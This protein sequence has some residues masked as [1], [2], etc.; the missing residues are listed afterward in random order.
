MALAP[1]GL[2]TLLCNALVLSNI[3]AV[4]QLADGGLKRVMIG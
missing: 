1:G 2:V 3:S 4:L